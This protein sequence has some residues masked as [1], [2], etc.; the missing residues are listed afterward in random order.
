MYTPIESTITRKR[1]RN[2]WLIYF[3]VSL[4]H[5]FIYNSQTDPFVLEN[6]WLN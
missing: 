5:Y 6:N 3:R 2:T 1:K 4:F